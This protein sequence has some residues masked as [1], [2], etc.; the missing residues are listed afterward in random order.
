MVSGE[1]VRR[2]RKRCGERGKKRKHK[3]CK[4]FKGKKAT[5]VARATHKLRHKQ[6]TERSAWGTDLERKQRC[7]AAAITPREANQHSRQDKLAASRQTGSSFVPRPTPV[8]C[9]SGVVTK[10]PVAASRTG[11]PV[12]EPRALVYRTPFTKEAAPFR[13]VIVS[14][15]VVARPSRR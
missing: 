13:D 4:T 14:A 12:T 6:M 5:H 2:S 11:V 15:P 1:S 7:G 8:K 9:Q 10:C 3:Q